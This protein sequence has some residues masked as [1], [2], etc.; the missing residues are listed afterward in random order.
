MCCVAFNWQSNLIRSNR[1]RSM[2]FCVKLLIWMFYQ[3]Y[4][5]VT[6]YLIFEQLDKCLHE[7]T[8]WTKTR[9]LLH[10]LSCWS[11][12]LFTVLQC[13]LYTIC[14]LHF[15]AFVR[16]TFIYIR[17]KLS[18]L[19][20]NECISTIFYILYIQIRSLKGFSLGTFDFLFLRWFKE[21]KLND[22]IQQVHPS[23]RKDIFV[24]W[25]INWQMSIFYFMASIN[26]KIITVC[27]DQLCLPSG[28]TY[29]LLR[30]TEIMNV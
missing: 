22:V 5:L 13:A 6:V 26:N 3:T 14:L 7:S 9:A 2:F 20:S 16:F 27:M 24:N 11:I 21:E 23:S 10:T 15:L 28:R 19:K 18:A 17:H 4:T 29:S 8:A 30:E 1:S 12:Y 25:L